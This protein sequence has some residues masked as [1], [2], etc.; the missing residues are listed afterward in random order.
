MG[1]LEEYINQYK[2]NYNKEQ[3]KQSALKAGNSEVEFENA[4]NAVQKP[5]NAT[6]KPIIT[7]KKRPTLI[8]VISGIMAAWI[9]YQILFSVFFIIE[10]PFGNSFMIF[11]LNI[12]INILGVVF[13]IYFFLLKKKQA[14][15]W[16]YINFGI[17]II[18]SL[19]IFNVAYLLFNAVAGWALWDYIKNKKI[20]N[21][22]VFT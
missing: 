1:T 10:N 11:A 20:D 3:L 9:S 16:L 4:W 12:I 17:A 22:P 19:V 5:T 18:Q 21:Q 14:L 7:K 6:Q 15:L 8:N 2:D 13:T